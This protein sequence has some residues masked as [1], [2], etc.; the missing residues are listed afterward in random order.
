M[1]AN[2]V[3]GGATFRIFAP[4]ARAVYVNG[5]FDGVDFFHRDK[6]DSLLLLKKDNY[7]TGFCAQS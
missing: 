4:S 2:P 1:G 5:I 3:P 6:D 7:W